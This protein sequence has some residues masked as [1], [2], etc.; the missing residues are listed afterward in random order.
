MFFI[1][2]GHDEDFHSCR[3]NYSLKEQITSTFVAE[4]SLDFFVNEPK[5]KYKRVQ[6]VVVREKCYVKITK[7]V[8]KKAK[9]KTKKLIQGRFQN[10]NP[11]LV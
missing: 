2:K 3:R 7:D 9:T 1:Y 5:V 4:N 6:Y 11:T 10:Q 8:I